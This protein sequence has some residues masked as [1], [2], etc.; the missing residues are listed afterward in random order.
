MPY[1]SARRQRPSHL[2]PQER[3]FV[4]S[5]PKGRISVYRNGDMVSE[6]SINAALNVDGGEIT[7]HLFMKESGEQIISVSSAAAEF[8]GLV[9][10]CELRE[11]VSLLTMEHD[12]D[13]ECNC[14]TCEKV[15]QISGNG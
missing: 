14:D 5:L 8:Y 15:R 11:V 4:K 12:L 6:S 3:A 7:L 1:L 13:G 10:Q 2:P 9:D